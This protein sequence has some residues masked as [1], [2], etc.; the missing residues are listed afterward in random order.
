MHSDYPMR[1]HSETRWA[2]MMDFLG[3]RWIYEPGVYRTIHGGYLPDFYLPDAGVFVEVKGPAPSQVEVNKAIDLERQTGCPVIFAY[4]RL[5]LD[6]LSLTDGSLAY[7]GGNRCM[8][9]SIFEIC[10]GIEKWRGIKAGAQFALAG[11]IKPEFDGVSIGQVLQEMVDGWRGRSAVEQDRAEKIAALND[12][13][14]AGDTVPDLPTMCLI[15]FAGIA[16]RNKLTP[17]SMEQTA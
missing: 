15:S 13:K 6:G 11:Q 12:Q 16:A 5:R 8:R 1:S 10:K 3:I 17:K 7:Y 14:H 2:A 9:F 4:G